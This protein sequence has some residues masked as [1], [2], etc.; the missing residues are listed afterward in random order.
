MGIIGRRC[1]AVVTWQHQHD[2]GETSATPEAAAERFGEK[3]AAKGAN[4]TSSL[5]A[6]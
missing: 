1:L 5:Q 4:I 2:Q 3:V 6:P